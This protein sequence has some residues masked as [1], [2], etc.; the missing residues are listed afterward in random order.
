[1]ADEKGFEHAWR[2]KFARALDKTAGQPV[3][4]RVIGDPPAPDAGPK[5][6]IDWTRAAMKRLDALLDADQR[7]AVMTACACRYPLADLQPM[8]EAYEATRDIDRVI[9]M[10]QERF[11]SFLRDDLA[12]GENE[13]AEVVHRGWGLAGIR[14]GRTILAT[15]IPKSGQLRRYLGETDPQKRRELYCH[16]PRVSDL[17]RWKQT[18]SPTYCYCGAGY[19]KGIW[20]EVLGRPVTVGLITSVLQGDEVCT[21][22]VHLPAGA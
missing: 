10:L 1:M 13:I 8:R 22:A 21:I 3:R 7:R 14:K 11:E 4:E 12:L 18:V 20:E 15:K 9:A 17:P 19:Y 6:V 16:C 5:T 2:A